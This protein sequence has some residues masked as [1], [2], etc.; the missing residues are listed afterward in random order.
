MNPLDR[1]ILESAEVAARPTPATEPVRED[2]EA[3]YVAIPAASSGL[4]EAAETF[5]LP[6][7]GRLWTSNVVQFVCFQVLFLAMQWLVTSMT[8]LRSA[9]GLIGFVQGGTIALASPMAGVL[10]DRRAKRD[11]ITIGRIGLATISI[12]V[13]TLAFSGAIAYWQIVVFSVLGG[14][15]TSV[16]S[17]ATQTFVVDVVGRR[18]THHAISL[19]AVGASFGMMGGGALGGFLLGAAGVFPTFLM[20][21]LGVVLSAIVVRSIPVAGRSLASAEA[22]ATASSP[23]ADLREGFAYVRARPPLLLALLACAMAVFNGALNPMRIFFARDVLDVGAEGLGWMAGVNGVGTLA[24]AVLAILRP[25][26]RHLG[27]LIAG[28]MLAFATGLVLYSFAF[29]F[30]WVLGVEGWLGFTGQL[31][32]ISALIGF[33]LAVPEA[34]RGRVL[35]MVFTLAQLG[36]LGVLGVGALADLVGD[37]TALFVFGAIPT[38]LLTGLLVFGWRTL[39]AMQEADA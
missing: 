25:P 13:G 15:L 36:F 7:Y 27:I 6:H 20:A 29:S 5:R 33:Q 38:V 17:P 31:W 30:G 9:V 4:A 14:L 18:R 34:M 35:S 28:T 10:V 32:N 2:D 19:N 23:L 22:G 16:L 11:L 3:G 8:P 24:A 39:E 26:Q 1:D 12:A 21:G 37:Q